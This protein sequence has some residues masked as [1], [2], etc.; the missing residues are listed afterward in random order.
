LLGAFIGIICAIKIND[1]LKHLMN[2][3]EV[4]TVKLIAKVTSILSALGLSLALASSVGAATSD[5]KIIERIK[6]AGNVC[7]E[8]DD[9]CGGAAAAVATTAGGARSGEEVYNSACA[10]CHSIGVAGAPKFGTS[11]WTD[12]AAKGIDSLLATAIS[13]INAM[14]PKGTCATCSDDELKIA[15][16][17][18][19]DSAP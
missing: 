8:G 15:I 14:P 7:L 9:S 5:E 4:S 13:G 19:I 11:E 2:R 17:Y 16:E 18:M 3:D 1:A 12:R 6:P 10:A